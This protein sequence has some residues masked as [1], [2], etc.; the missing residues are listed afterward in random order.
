MRVRPFPV[1]A[2]FALVLALPA[3]A[4]RLLPMDVDAV[5]MDP[6]AEIGA[7]SIVHSPL[8]D[9]R[10]TSGA[11]DDRM[12]WYF[13]TDS[14]GDFVR[15]TVSYPDDAPRVCEIFQVADSTAYWPGN[16]M[17]AGYVTGFAFPRTGRWVA[18]SFYFFVSSAPQ[19]GLVF[20]SSMA[21]A[22]CAVRS[23][24]V[25][26]MD[27]TAGLPQP[28]AEAQSPGRRKM[29]LFSEDPI[30]STAYGD[31]P[32]ADDAHLAR[33]TAPLEQQIAYLK[34]TLQNLVIYDPVKL[35]ATVRTTSAWHLRS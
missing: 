19:F 1:P 2:L 20:K 29:G 5:A 23:L 24:R 7:S 10:Q 9:Y 33:F 11:R 4:Q 34:R 21:G 14:L 16:S 25:E 32:I 22:P 35:T 27:A 3:M 30:L 18:Q 15:A 17:G 31:H 8:G 28:P 26:K 6:D 13:N 12:V